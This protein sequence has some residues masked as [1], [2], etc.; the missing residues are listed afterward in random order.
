MLFQPRYSPP[1]LPSGAAF[2]RG[3]VWV[4][5]CLY[6]AR[7]LSKTKATNAHTN[8]RKANMSTEA[9]QHYTQEQ[10]DNLCW[11]KVGYKLEDGYEPRVPRRF[12][13][14]IT[15][16]IC[17]IDRGALWWEGRKNDHQPIAVISVTAIFAGDCHTLRAAPRQI[18]D[19]EEILP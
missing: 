1:N 14:K 15:G 12:R 2:M 19:L 6:R 11:R 13:D 10:F 9:T 17:E 3:A 7:W 4:S 16:Q 5:R 18:T 8:K